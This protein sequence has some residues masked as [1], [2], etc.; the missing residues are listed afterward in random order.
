MKEGEDREGKII[1]VLLLYFIFLLPVITVLFIIGFCLT[2]SSGRLYLEYKKIAKN[3]TEEVTA[4]VFGVEREYTDR[5]IIGYQN[6]SYEYNGQKYISKVKYDSVFIDRSS[7]DSS[8]AADEHFVK[9]R[10][11]VG[12]ELKI[13]I[14]PKEPSKASYPIKDEKMRTEGILALIGVF[15]LLAFINLL[16]V[17]VVLLIRVFKKWSMQKLIVRKGVK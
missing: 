15:C 9:L 13:Y 5:G 17:F 11:T 16:V 2:D 3:Y 12:T 1:G 8:K 4:V 6:I 7:P 10:D 14:D